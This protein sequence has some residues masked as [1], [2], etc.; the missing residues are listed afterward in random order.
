MRNERRVTCGARYHERTL[1]EVPVTSMVDYVRAARDSFAS[2]PLCRVDALCLAWLSYLRFPDELGASNRAGVRLVDLAGTWLR[3]H[4]TAGLHNPERS[5]AL[6]DAIAASPRFANVRACL[7]ASE[8]ADA[9]S[10]QFSA[11]TFVLPEGVGAVVAYRGTDDSV[12]GWKENFRLVCDEAIPAQQR[13]LRYL[14]ETVAELGCTFWVCGHSK[15]GALAAYAC[16]M[17]PRETSA[18][19]RTCYSF[20]GPGLAP[21]LHQRKGW[22]DDVPLHKLVPR[23]S[24]VGMLFERSQADLTIVRS[25]AEG[26]LQHDPFTWEIAGHDVVVEQGMDYDAWRLAQRLNDW[27][28]SMTP[29]DR[30]SFAELLGWLI[31]TTAEATFS[32]L[33]ARWQTNTQ[34]MKAALS[35]APAADRALF[36]RVMDDLVT[37]LV[38]GSSQEHARPDAATPEAAHAAARRVEDLSAHVGDRLSRIDELLGM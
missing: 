15:G 37:T 30:T 2:R 16:A 32:G 21:E 8:A 17:A 20:D 25:A 38:L 7:H 28:C 5:G 24:L 18:C 34:A 27:L 31:D 19:V 36:E 14:E 4:V 29:T 35:A 26:L 33:L 1:R 22:H 13:A 12:R 23:A 3:A 6:L 9:A 10:M 11:T